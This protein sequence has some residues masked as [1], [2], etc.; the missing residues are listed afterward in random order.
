MKRVALP[1][2]PSLWACAPAPEPARA[3]AE[4]GGAS[5]PDEERFSDVI[6]IEVLPS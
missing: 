1:L 2:I 3:T 6:R 5:L 4:P